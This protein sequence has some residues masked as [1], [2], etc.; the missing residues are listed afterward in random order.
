MVK[1]AFEFFEEQVPERP[2]E[3]TECKKP[4]AIWYTELIGN[5]ISQTG[6]CSDCPILR[7]KLHGQT[8]EKEMGHMVGET[9]LACGECNTSLEALRVGASL[10]CSNCYEVFDDI[11]LQELLILDKVP[12]RVKANK[13]IFPLHIG[14]SP[15]EVREISPS[16]RLLALNEALNETLKREDYEQAAWLRDQIRALTE[17]NVEKSNGPQ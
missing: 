9:S 11:I 14:R 7:R 2:I 13:K 8:S 4:I 16:L 12:P 3:C 17:E 6:M 5:N 10:G 1:K 15:G